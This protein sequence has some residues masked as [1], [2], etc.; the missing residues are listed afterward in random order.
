MFTNTYVNWN[1]FTIL[2][3]LNLIITALILHE[4][5]PIEWIKIKIF[6]F[7]LHII[8]SKKSNF[9]IFTKFAYIKIKWIE[10]PKSAI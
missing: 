7:S 6:Y 10:A 1:Y 4:L 8:L 9:F 3:F 5:L 2:D